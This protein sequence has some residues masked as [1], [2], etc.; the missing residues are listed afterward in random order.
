MSRTKIETDGASIE[1]QPISSQEN[2]LDTA[3]SVDK[4]RDI[5]FGSQI[6]NYEARFV[7]LEEA[8][9]RETSELKDTM[10]KRFESI[11]LFFKNE[12]EALAIRLRAER[13]ERTSLISNLERD[14][15]DMQSAFTRRLNDIDA[16]MSE[17]QSALRKELMTESRKLQEEIEQRHD[18]IR[19]LME[20]RVSDLRVQKTDRAL[21][22]DLFR[23]MA[24]QLDNDELSSPE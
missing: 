10:R 20:T 16:A 24:A 3:A 5:I 9:V 14:M 12:S 13:E 8:L 6:K 2:S 17:G 22:A 1:S 21:M 7:R 4:I 15:K 18:S 11:E 23:E 19:S